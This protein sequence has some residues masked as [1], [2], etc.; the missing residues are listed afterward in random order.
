[1]VHITNKMPVVPGSQPGAAAGPILGTLRITRCP[2]AVQ[3][4]RSFPLRRGETTIGRDRG[5]LVVLDD[6]G[7]S[8]LHARLVVGAG[9]PLLFD[10]QSTNGT[11]LNGTRIVEVKVAKGDT[12]LLGST[13]LVYE[14]SEAP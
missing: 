9:A 3:V 14:P 6:A 8:G 2:D 7:V 11:F 13:A 1:M 4:G 10:A 5:N 12:L